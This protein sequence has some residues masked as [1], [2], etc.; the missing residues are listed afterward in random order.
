MNQK[1]I[2]ID[3]GGTSVKMGLFQADGTLLKKWEIPTRKEDG[4]ANILGDIAASIRRQMKG[5]GIALTELA[6]AGMGLPG[7][8]LP[9]GH[10]EFCVNLGW[11]AGNPQEELSRLLDGIPV[12]SGNDANVAALGEMWQGGGRGYKNL[13]MVTLGTGVGGG[14]ILNEKIWTGMQGVGGEIGHM[15]IVE[16][17]KE[18]CNCHGYG[19]LEQVASATGIARVARRLLE[20]DERP[21]VLRQA[22]N[23]NAKHVLD[24]AKAGDELALEALNTSCYYLGWALAAVTMVLDPE[25]YLIGGG[26]SRAGTFLT[27]LIRKYHNEL[28]PM[29][30]K[31]ADIVLAELGNDA[32]IYGAAKLILG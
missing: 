3:I 12:K 9:N 15:H 29:A 1:C 16:G 6:G 28:S 20:K 30:T 8:V 32:G 2:G 7:P 21:S 17:E 4:G 18:Q 27:D 11:K 24:A 31:K 19:C 14:V 13:V 10:I 25:A 26:V 23:L 5:E 22:A